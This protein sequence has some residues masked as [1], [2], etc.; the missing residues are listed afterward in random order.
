[1]RNFRIIE[2]DGKLNVTYES[3][4]KI[5]GEDDVYTHQRDVWTLFDYK[6]EEKKASMNIY[7]SIDL[8][9]LYMWILEQSGISKS[10]NPGVL[11]EILDVLV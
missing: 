9:C 5:R 3:E 7:R 10:Y 1:M 11:N 8:R 6:P 2:E 4:L